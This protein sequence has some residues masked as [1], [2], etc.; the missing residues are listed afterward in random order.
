M[1]K[2]V[3]E[4]GYILKR[5]NKAKCCANICQGW[6]DTADE[7]KKNHKNS[8]ASDKLLVM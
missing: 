7:Q 8:R 2:P 6:S 3:K 4:F 5:I 1:C